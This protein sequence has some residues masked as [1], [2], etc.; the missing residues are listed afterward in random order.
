MCLIVIAHNVDS[1]LPLIVAGN[2]DEFHGRPTQDAHWWPDKPDILGGRDLQAGGTWLAIHRNGRFAAVT[3]YRDAVP[4]AGKLKSRGHLVTGFLE[5]TVDPSAY[6]RSINPDQ[7]DGFNLLVG[8]GEQLAYLCN[9]DGSN[10][11][12][13]P[14]IYG[15][16]NASLDAPWPKV[17]RSKATLE[18]LIHQ[19]AV[20]ETQ[21]MRLLADKNKARAD[22]VII[23]GLAFDKA[24]AL[25]APFIVL[26]DYGTRCSTVLLRDNN[27]DV[28]FSEK[29]FS[30]SGDV[31]GQSDFRFRSAT[32]AA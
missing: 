14:G 8:D 22:E 28:R 21:L 16:A 7:Y 12:L 18:Q 6:V 26:P 1:G 27:G 4:K 30:A 23:D 25:T 24:H 5:A 32:Q 2:R 19:K 11:E 3:N 9:R 10:R 31:L 15:V 13:A 17:E 29:R 20:N